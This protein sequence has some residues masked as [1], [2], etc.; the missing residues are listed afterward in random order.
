MSA[1]HAWDYLSW[2]VVPRC[3]AVPETREVNQH[4]SGAKYGAV[5]DVDVNLLNDGP[6]LATIVLHVLRI[7]DEPFYFLDQVVTL[8]Q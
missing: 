2:N 1:S 6:Q 4:N 3:I 8:E 5:G 7:L